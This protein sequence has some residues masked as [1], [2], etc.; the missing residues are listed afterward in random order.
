MKKRR[1][2]LKTL[3]P[4]VK[5]LV[6][7][8][9]LACIVVLICLIISA[10]SNIAASVFLQQIISVI[11]NTLN[12]QAGS[13]EVFKEIQPKLFNILIFMVSLY[14]VGILSSIVYNQIMAVIGQGFLNKIRQEMFNKMES[15]PIKYFD[16]HLHG[17]I[18]SHYTNDVD[19]LRQF[20]CQS[21]P[22]CI[23][24]GLSIVFAIAIMLTYSV[25]LFLIVIIGAIAMLLVTRK[26]GGNSAKYFMKMQI[27]TGKCEGYIEEMM[28]GA[29][30][31]K[32]FSHEEACKEEFDK[33]NNQLFDDTKTANH[34]SNILMPILG[35]IGNIQYSL[36]SIIGVIF[37]ITSVPNISITGIGVM[38]MS[39]IIAFLPMSKQFS[40]S[41]S[42]ISQQVSMIAMAMA[43]TQRILD[44]LAEKP[45]T[46]EGYITLVNTGLV[47]GKLVETAS[48]T[49]SWAW[50]VPNENGSELVPLTGDIKLEDVDF[51]YYPEKIVLHDVNIFANPGQK[52]AFVGATGAGKTTITNLINRFY[53]IQDGKI[54][55]DGID[56]TNIKKDDLRRSLGIVLQ[57]TNLFTGTVMENIR[58]GRLDATDEEVYKA[59]KIANAYDFIT[60]LPEGFNTMLTGDGANLSQGQRQLLSIA[61]AAV[62]DA[63]VMILDEATSSIDT[64][65]ESLVQKGT[66]QLM[67]GRTVFVIA[68]RL[69]TVRNSDCIMVLDHGRIIERGSH[70]DLLEEKGTYYQLYTGAFELE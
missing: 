35:N 54:L 44:L 50:K 28:H 58:Y 53:E 18:M 43:G 23:S 69:S 42:N 37:Y 41:V 68:H 59:A 30:V 63:P 60:R 16:R 10:I 21:L 31:V 45:E 57:D 34:F 39:I 70:N 67:V 3:V 55:Y 2:S 24:T 15:L 52:I 36:I 14:G 13:L 51:G 64:R 47:D 9:K 65:T 1:I 38:S 40:Q 6:S 46:D 12:D 17:D 4:I 8:Y 33:I 27:S 20:V 19:S 49:N 22:Q 48:R 26:I 11:E 56:I 29:K 7:S 66:D 62:A 32:V 5:R 25:W 61:R